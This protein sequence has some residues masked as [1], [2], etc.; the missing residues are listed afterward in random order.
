MS[1]QEEAAPTAAALVRAMAADMLATFPEL[2]TCL[3]AVVGIAEGELTAFVA[4]AY[5]RHFFDILYRRAEVFQTAAADFLPGV[6]MAY[7]WARNISD[8][9]RD[10]LWKHLQLI[11]FAA[12]AGADDVKSFGDAAQLF[13]AVDGEHLRSKL[14]ETIEGMMGSDQATPDAARLDDHLKSLMGGRIGRLAKE[15][16]DEALG[17]FGDVGDGG[18]ARGAFAALIKDPLRLM[19]LVKRIGSK[20]DQQIKSGELKEADLLEEASELLEK[21]KDAPGMDGM[22]D[23]MKRMG[24]N[25]KK[26]VKRA[27]A[28]VDVRLRTARTKDRLREK[29]AQRRTAATAAA[30]TAATAAAAATAV[31]TVATVPT[32]AKRKRRKRKGGPKT[33]TAEGNGDPQTPNDVAPC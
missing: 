3:E 1:D 14:E 29:L 31:A 32:K 8:A 11:L 22:Q 33:D 10:S 28:Q 23:L 9:T 20:I 25:T 7:V 19:R 26:D 6:D 16:A 21:M 5:P 12:V 15:I 13:E 18:D 17:E 27:K 24:V 30:A 2:D 4:E